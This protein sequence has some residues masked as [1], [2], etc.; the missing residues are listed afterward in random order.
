MTALTFGSSSAFKSAVI[1]IPSWSPTSLAAA[2]FGSTARMSSISR[3][4]FYQ[5][6]SDP[7]SQSN[8]TPTIP[9]LYLAACSPRSHAGGYG[10][11]TNVVIVLMVDDLAH[12]ARRDCR[13]HRLRTNST[14]STTTLTLPTRETYFPRRANTSAAPGVE[15]QPAGSGHLARNLAAQP[16]ETA[17]IRR[18]SASLRRTV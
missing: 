6:P 7:T 4:C 15:D 3:D 2:A 14:P 11:T 1:E 16:H 9:Y 13:I 8:T 5:G 10:M 17:V 12:L 18:R